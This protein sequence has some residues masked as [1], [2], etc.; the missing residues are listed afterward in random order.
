MSYLQIFN[1]KSA[2]NRSCRFLYN[3]FNLFVHIYIYKKGFNNGFFYIFYYMYNITYFIH[4]S[5][6]QWILIKLKNT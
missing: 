6:Q 4:P 3:Y 5:I 2:L 1:F